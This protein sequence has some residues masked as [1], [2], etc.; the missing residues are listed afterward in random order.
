MDSLLH[1]PEIDEIFLVEDGSEDNSLQVCRK[2][3]E[4]HPHINV[5]QHPDGLNK[6]AP[7]SRNL[8]L[9]ASKN[10]WIQFMDA[11]DEL[12]PGKIAGQV[13]LLTGE[14]ELI[15]GQFYYIDIEGNS[16]L[17][18]PMRDVWSGLIATRL[19]Y[20]S[21][22]L[23]RKS[24]LIRAGEWDPNLINIQEYNLI[25]SMLKSGARIKFSD[26][27]L[28]KIYF[29]PDSIRNSPKKE[30]EKRDHYFVFR[31]NIRTYLIENNMFTLRRRHY[32]HSITG[33]MLRYHRPDFKVHLNNTYYSIYSSI[34]DLK[35]NT[36][37][38]KIAI[39]G[40]VILLF[41]TYLIH[42]L[43]D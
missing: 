26:Q 35:K 15:V 8:G 16:T 42:E 33:L 18:T 21:S 38:I 6:G 30:T 23:W 29:Q 9:Q 4:K 10:E 32:F 13:A 3:A 41:I 27:A 11:D 17:F 25:F 5:L 36:N 2:L 43:L 37:K 20:T 24:A 14:E 7:E 19:G 12:L 31:E 40:G 34:R 1:Q 22:N 28:T 39:S